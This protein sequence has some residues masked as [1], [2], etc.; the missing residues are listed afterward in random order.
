MFE[1]SNDSNE[2]MINKSIELLSCKD[3]LYQSMSHVATQWVNASEHH[4]T[5]LSCN[6]KAWLGQA[7]C[8]F[9]HK[10]SEQATC[11]AWW[12]ISDEQRFIA[13][14]VA[15]MVINEWEQENAGSGICLKLDLG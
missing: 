7:A 10:A 1:S 9:E 15:T 2:Y 13:N 12:M 11:K 3:A 4:L 8:C 14:A 5:D 6:K